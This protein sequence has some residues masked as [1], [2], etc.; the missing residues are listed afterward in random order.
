MQTINTRLK[1]LEYNWLMRV[2]VTPVL[3]NTFHENITDICPKCNLCKD[4]FFHCV[5]ACEEILK[6]W[7]GVQNL[8]S[9]IINVTIPLEPKCFILNLYPNNL[10][11]RRRRE[12]I[13]VYMCTLQAKCLIAL[14]WKKVKA[15][16]IVRWLKE[17]ATNVIGENNIYYKGQI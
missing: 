1:L 2:Y 6:F 9:K 3:L 10:N 7:K 4:N 13:F 8:I 12:H 11:L 5:W 15:P 14:H 16:S 17:L